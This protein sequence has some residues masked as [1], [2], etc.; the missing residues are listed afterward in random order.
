MFEILSDFIEGECQPEQVEWYGEY[1]HKIG[2]KYVRDEMQELYDW[3]NQ[4][5]QKDYPAI[6]DRLWKHAEKHS[7]VTN[8]VEIEDYC[9]EYK[10]TWKTDKDKHL[11]QLCLK[12]LNNVEA[13]MD[14]DLKA[15]LHRI[16]EIMPYMW[17]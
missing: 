10:P 17:T 14:E 5:Y 3:W 8:W 9:Q 6:C 4:V 11:Y 16:I 15:N 12:A 13:D 7:P 1:G 2:D